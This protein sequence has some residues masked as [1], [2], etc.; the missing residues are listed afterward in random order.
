[1]RVGPKLWCCNLLCTLPFLAMLPGCGNS[2]GPEAAPPVVPAVPTV[3]APPIVIAVPSPTGQINDTGISS[4]SCYKA[5]SDTLVPCSDANAVLLNAAQDGAIGRDVDVVTNTAA[6]GKLG[7]SYTKIGPV[8]QV[9]P[10]NST[11]WSCVKD[12]VT[13]L[14]WE[15]KTSDGGLRDFNKQY[16]NLDG[17]TPNQLAG[18]NV[19]QGN[20]EPSTTQINAPTNTVGYVTAV[21]AQ[22]LCGAANWRLPTASELQ[23]IV[24]HSVPAPG[25]TID[26]AWL[27]ST[28][29]VSA[30]WTST[31]LPFFSQGNARMVRFSFGGSGSG[32]RSQS[33]QLVRLV[34][35]S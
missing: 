33:S 30:Y 27:G 26:T 35:S 4:A 34:R 25:P 12:N 13:G 19:S 18:P 7:F 29:V 32:S 16:T 21:N 14:I 20:N 15:V 17:T 31:Q 9:L 5:S 6:D 24:D 3:P 22:S 8:G 11:Q 23:G 28:A 1:M 10:A 2:S